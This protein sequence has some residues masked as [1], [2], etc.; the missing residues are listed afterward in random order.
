MHLF[1][2]ALIA[3]GYLVADRILYKAKN[4]LHVKPRFHY[5]LLSIPIK[6][7]VVLVLLAWILANCDCL[8]GKAHKLFFLRK[9]KDLAH[10]H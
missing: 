4:V 6:N 5:I 8:C 2:I 7:K 9:K 3:Q 1:F 10:L